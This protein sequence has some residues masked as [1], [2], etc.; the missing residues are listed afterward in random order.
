MSAIVETVLRHRRLQSTTVASFYPLALRASR[1]LEPRI[2]RGYLWSERHPLPLRAR[3]LSPLAGPNWMGPA[4]HTFT[5]EL[6]Q[7]FNNQGKL[8][9]ARDTDVGTDLQ[10]LADMGLD[11]VVAD[12]P[13]ISVR[14]LR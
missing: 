7:R 4:L 3:W 11:G 10:H 9:L 1:R 2:A 8:V 13:E 6:L 5:S 14:Q 12:D